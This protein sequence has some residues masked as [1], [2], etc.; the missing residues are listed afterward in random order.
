MDY[1][2]LLPNKV[3]P[4]GISTALKDL[5]AGKTNERYNNYYRR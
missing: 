4:S 5:N 2:A 3:N 1:W